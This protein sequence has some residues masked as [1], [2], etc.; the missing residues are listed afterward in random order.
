MNFIPASFD[1]VDI[2]ERN[3][4]EISDLDREARMVGNSIVDFD[5]RPDLPLE[6]FHYGKTRAA[7]RKLRACDSS[8]FIPLDVRNEFEHLADPTTVQSDIAALVGKYTARNGVKAGAILAVSLATSTG[9]TRSPP[10]VPLLDIQSPDNASKSA[11]NLLGNGFLR[12]GQ[13]G[14]IN[15]PTGVGKSVL[16]M[17]AACCFACGRPFFGIRPEKPLRTLIAQS[18]NDD[19]DI[20]EMRD[21][22]FAALQ[23][24]AGEVAMIKENVLTHR[25]FKSGRDWVHELDELTSTHKP[26]LII[27]DP[28]F[29]YA[30]VD[31]AKDQPG[32]S[33]FL[34]GKIQPLLIKRNCGIVFIHHTNKPPGTAKERIQ[35]QGGDFAYSGS[36][37]NELANWPRFVI[38]L[39]SMGS[40]TVFEL[41]IGKRWK[42]AGIVDEQG[43][44]LDRVLIQHGP[45]G[46]HWKAATQTDLTR[47]MERD[48]GTTKGGKVEASWA[49]KIA[50][51]FHAK[52]E[53]GRAD[54][55][56]IAKALK[57]SERTIRREFG[58][59]FILR[60]G[61]DVFVL[62]NSVIS[63]CVE[64]TQD[65]LI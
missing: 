12:R 1:C 34:R 29:A 64:A 40:R 4:R 36:G 18:E 46:I 17:Q 60:H 58:P 57:T 52:H 50:K 11:V 13:G 8:E 56:V 44:A 15:G 22:I 25:S 48:Q 43:Q 5:A 32:L 14:L 20:A 55:E 63:L 24:T 26:D 53:N 65:D 62:S 31:I 27:A 9:P 35:W 39:R 59:S 47:S 23:F 16:T 19:A 3:W 7:W 38:A 28:L 42:R 49:D 41:R 54:L 33:A 6:V 51:A 30:G 10:A 2:P 21:G 61:E 45:T 37:H